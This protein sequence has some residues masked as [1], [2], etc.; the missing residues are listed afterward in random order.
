MQQKSELLKKSLYEFKP[1]ISD[2]EKTE[3]DIIQSIINN[4]PFI[5]KKLTMITFPHNLKMQ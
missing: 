3:H 5:L 2:F 1:K 4:K